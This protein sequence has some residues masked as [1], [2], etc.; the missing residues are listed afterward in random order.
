M[1]ITYDNLTTEL[2]LTIFDNT[3]LK[4]V[5]GGVKATKTKKKSTETFIHAIKTHMGD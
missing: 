2:T 3:D 5:S 4:V 1:S